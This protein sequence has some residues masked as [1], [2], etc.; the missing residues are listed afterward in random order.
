M[1]RRS[2]APIVAGLATVALVAGA[3]SIAGFPAS[4]AG[5]PTPV[6]PKPAASSRPEATAGP[7]IGAPNADVTDLIV[8]RLAHPTALT[9][10]SVVDPADRRLLFE[11]PDGLV[12]RDWRTLVSVTPDGGSTRV[13]VSD[14]EGST[15][16]AR[17]SVAG[18]WRLPTIGVAHQASGLSADGRTLVLEESVAT[19]PAAP[20]SRSRFAIV[21]TGGSKPPRIVTLAGS[22]VFDALSPDGRSMYLIEHLAGADP[23]HYQVRRFDVATGSLQDGAIVDKRNV[24]EQMNG[25]AVTQEAG[26]NG[27]VY[28]IYRGADGAFIHA[29]DTADGVAFCIDLPGTDDPDATTATP[30]GLLADPSGN[31]LFVV[32]P[33]RKSVSAIDLADFSIR[34]TAALA[35]LSTIRFAKLESAEPVAGPAAL[36]RDGT[37]LYVAD[38]TGIDVVRVADLTTTGHLGGSLSFRSLAVGSAG[39]IYVVDDAGRAMRLGDASAP[40]TSATSAAPAADGRYSAIVAIVPMH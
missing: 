25:Y 16:P 34:R 8:L 31:A 3:C 12:S 17:I 11:L 22:F 32:D 14:P 15:Q 1:T 36:S 39:T 19:A 37:T 29:L 35:S 21:A 38:T 33:I 20:T 6:V 2:F 7:S 28:T 24:G 40:A 13:Q 5:A 23:T 26:Q 9:A 27:W 4:S 10:Y 30:W 18:A